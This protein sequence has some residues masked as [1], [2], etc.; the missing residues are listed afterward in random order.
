MADIEQV[1][2]VRQGRDAVA[3]WREQHPGENMDLYNSYM[4]H[5]R[6][7]MVD[8]SGSDLRETDFM[9]AMLRR[10]NLSGCYLNP[11]H[12]YRADLREADL[13]KTLMNRANLRGA[14]L[15]AANLD[16]AD[17]DSAILSNANLT[18]ASLKGANLSRVNLDRSNLTDADLTGAIFHG[19]ALTRADLSGAQL[20]GADFYSAIFNDTPTVGTKFNGSIVGYTVFQNCDLSQAEGLEQIRHDAPSTLGMDSLL[21]CGG[22]LP[23][24]FLRGVGSP[25]SLLAFQK[26]LQGGD[27]VTGD[28]FI[29]CADADIPFGKKLENDLRDLGIRCWLFAEQHRGNALVDRRSTSEE[30]EI[31]RW[32]R[33][34]EKLIVVCSQAGLD[35][36]TLRNDI[37]KAKEEQ[38]Q[39][40]AWL[41]Y[42]VSPDS[43]MVQPQGRN[44]RN[45]SY[46]HVVFNLQGHSSGSEEYRGELNRLAG[47]LKQSQPAKA[48]VPSVSNQL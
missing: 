9:G 43:T 16:G 48:G 5:V 22:R 37:S 2:I 40:D 1:Q 17:L 41:L 4:S 19:A 47:E 35:S 34:Y 44:A 6:I 11:V 38:M 28:F 3:S 7:P 36:E 33:H 46:E 24:G 13:S 10:A 30:E 25:D 26:S 27:A 8:L 14:D 15:R 45:L 12:M 23:D 42:V 18:G 31:E 29:A 20:D 21:R 39:K 32:V